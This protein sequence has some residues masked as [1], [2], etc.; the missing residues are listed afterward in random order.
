MCDPISI[1]AIGGMV[2]GKAMNLYGQKQAG[3]A[4]QKAYD[5]E[6]ANQ[7]RLRDDNLKT[8]VVS[9]E[10]NAPL[11]VNAEVD[12]QMALT[13]SSQ[14]DAKSLAQAVGG[15]GTDGAQFAG[16]VS[17]GAQGSA[18]RVDDVA[19]RAATLRAFGLVGEA[20]ALEKEQAGFRIG[21]NN[22][23]GA[24]ALSRLPMRL[25]AAANQGR[26]WR[27]AGQAFDK[28]GSGLLSSG[29][30]GIGGMM[31]G[32]KPAAGTAGSFGGAPSVKTGG[33]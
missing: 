12:K 3:N 27:I 11:A 32:M 25:N 16:Q 20:D 1:A 28:F 21:A 18:A 30:G 31:P 33:P 15:T 8:A 4:T 5:E 22:L 23:E 13:P 26:G 29:L 2:G 7:A 17:R 6:Q 14:A 19:R 10:K 9:A 24:D